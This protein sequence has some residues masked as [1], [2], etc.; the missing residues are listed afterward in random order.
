MDTEGRR[1]VTK[2]ARRAEKKAVRASHQT[3][4]E[5]GAKAGHEIAPEDADNDLRFDRRTILNALVLFTRTNN[6]TDDM[7]EFI[8]HAPEDVEALLSEVSC[9]RQMV[10]KLKEQKETAVKEL[11]AKRIEASKAAERIVDMR[12][13][14]RTLCK[15]MG[16][17]P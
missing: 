16:V 7:L 4:V 11:L 1:M 9:L 3:A 13:A 15:E 10:A 8:A 2:G 5:R 6:A 17:K 12:R 14:W